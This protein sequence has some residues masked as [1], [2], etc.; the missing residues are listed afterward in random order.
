V[1]LEREALLITADAHYQ[2][3]ALHLGAVVS[4]AGW[5]DAV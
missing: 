1:A 4:L 5:N 3:K 2:R